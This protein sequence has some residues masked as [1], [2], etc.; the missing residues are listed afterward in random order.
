MGNLVRAIRSTVSFLSPALHG[1]GASPALDG[2]T[3]WALVG[4]CFGTATLI[5]AVIG[6]WVPD[7]VPFATYF[8]AIAIA[9]LVGGFWPGIFTLVLSMLAGLFVFSHAGDVPGVSVSGAASAALFAVSA[10]LQLVLAVMLRNLFW[11][12]RR[13]EYR[14]R[15]LVQASTNIVSVFDP[16]GACREPQPGWE[17]LSGMKWPSYSGMKWLDAVHPDD[18]EKVSLADAVE[19]RIREAASNDWRWFSVR[20]V[21]LLDAD[22]KVEEIV[23]SLRDVTERKTAQERRELLLGDLR[24]RLTNFIAVIRALVNAAKPKDNADVDA[25]AQTFLRRVG[26]LQSAGDLVLKANAQEV[27][28]ADVVPAVLAPFG[29]E[30]RSKIFIE[31]PR[32]LL[33]EQTIGGIALACN[34]LATNAAKYGALSN[35]DGQ[36]S[37]RWESHLEGETERVTFAWIERDGPPVTPPTRR[38]FGTRIVSSAVDSEQNGEVTLDYRPEGLSCRMSF[39]RTRTQHAALV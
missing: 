9:G 25:F 18:R 20:T 19:V 30:L 37:I 24:H 21:P 28:L 8:P 13:N 31:G 36:V 16:A 2:V 32:L 11:Q 38:G 12:S 35:H 7:V 17:A 23:A 4:L 15:A 39:T 26:A 10:S 34:E 27:D 22:G 5:R 3:Q 29:S 14:Y 1:R 33:K 6:I